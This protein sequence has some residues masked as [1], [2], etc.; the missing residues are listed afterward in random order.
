MDYSSFVKKIIDHNFEDKDCRDWLIRTVATDFV[1][2]AFIDNKNELLDIY[3]RKP[4][5]PS[6]SVSHDLMIIEEFKKLIEDKRKNKFDISVVEAIATRF[7]DTLAR[8]RLFG[9]T[10]LLDF[11]DRVYQQ[12]ASSTK[13]RFLEK[14][15]I[16][17]HEPISLSKFNVYRAV[18]VDGGTL[19][20]LKFITEKEENMISKLNSCNPLIPGL[21]L[22]NVVHLESKLKEERIALIMRRLSN[23]VASEPSVNPSEI[24]RQG[25]RIKEALDGMHKLGLV[26]LDV[27]LQ[28]ILVDFSGSWFLSDFDFTCKMFD[29][30]PENHYSFYPL[31]KRKHIAIPQFDLYLLGVHLVIQLCCRDDLTQIQSGSNVDEKK[32][33]NVLNGFIHKDPET[34]NLKSFISQL[35]NNFYVRCPETCAQ[36]ELYF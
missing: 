27:K 25:K 20:M 19:L 7:Y 24:L 30:I 11:Y 28:N 5:T 35:L 8:T 32:V 12:P 2:Q 17:I 18:D 36:C 14:T 26:H 13:Q 3:R 4:V 1:I 10:A 33:I 6:P 16:K 22:G 34:N 15:N 21:I 23:D 9:E 31:N 29:L